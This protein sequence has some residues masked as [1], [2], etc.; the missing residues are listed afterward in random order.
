VWLET[1]HVSGVTVVALG[2]REGGNVRVCRLLV[3]LGMTIGLVSVGAAASAEPVADHELPFPC[4]QS[5]TGTTRSSHSPDKRAI[6]FNRP[7]DLGDPVVAS[8][9]GVVLTADTVDDSG[10]GRWVLLD[11]GNGERSLYA[12]LKAVFVT[13]GQRID[14]GQQL[15]KVGSTGNSTGPH[16][17]YEQ[18]Q[19]DTVV[20]PWFSGVAFT[21]GSTLP[22]ANCADV[23]LAA[24][25][26]RGAAAEPTVFRRRTPARFLFR[27]PGGGQ[28][29]RRLG[30]STD[31]PVVGDWDGSGHANPGRFR[32]S[33]RAFLLKTPAGRV[34]F[35]FGL[36]TDKPVAGDW[37]GDGSWEVGVWR[38]SAASFLLRRAD[39][40]VSTVVL[41]ATDELPVTGDWDGDGVTDLGTFDPD[42]AT[43]TLRRVDASGTTWLASVVF[44]EPGQLPV[45]GDWDGNG[46]TDLGTWD[47]A[48]S[49]FHQRRAPEPTAPAR[50]RTSVRH[51]AG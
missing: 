38:S 1:A 42:T 50:T 31:E 3:V 24:N 27:K 43:F 9:P 37:D 39:G 18:K 32:P 41:G 12:H 6:D 35:R 28:G 46:T 48:T 21:F 30:A 40:T 49:T 8:A 16:L 17:H 51:G 4:G 47:R 10:Y 22:S 5:W 34:S 19:L 7:D 2:R 13:S 15:G 23:P 11:H 25:W 14:L 33:S 44:G 26:V 20:W 45:A 29:A 36:R